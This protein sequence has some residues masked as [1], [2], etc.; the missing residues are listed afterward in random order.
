MKQEEEYEKKRSDSSLLMGLGGFFVNLFKDKTMENQTNNQD[1][2]EK[3]K[4]PKELNSFGLL[5]IV[6]PR[7]TLN[8]F[9][10]TY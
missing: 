8:L 10:T 3:S 1:Q 9:L 7:L 6:I 2:P 4:K 5:V